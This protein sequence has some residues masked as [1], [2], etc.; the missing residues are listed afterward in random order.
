MRTGGGKLNRDVCLVNVWQPNLHI[1]SIKLIS[2]TTSHRDTSLLKP[3]V[4]HDRLNHYIMTFVFPRWV[5]I[6]TVIP[7]FGI[8]SVQS[9]RIENRRCQELK[10]KRRSQSLKFKKQRF[11]SKPKV[12]LWRSAVTQ[13]E[14][15]CGRC[16]L[17]TAPVGLHATGLHSQFSLH[18][19]SIIML[20]VLQWVFMKWR[21]VFYFV[22][23]GDDTSF[24]GCQSN[25]YF[26]MP[27]QIKLHK[28]KTRDSPL[29]L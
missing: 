14:M 24:I 16:W 11:I 5:T 29:T 3:G 4:S 18:Q 20:M 10:G 12:F 21:V 13:G 17:M 7:H 8:F 6:C 28:V 27:Q 23:A 22:V 2:K 26:K 19:Y 9:G 1:H 15:H 25:W